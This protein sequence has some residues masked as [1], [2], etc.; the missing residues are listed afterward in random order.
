MVF[1]VPVVPITT[2][3]ERSRAYGRAGDRR[4]RCRTARIVA[5]AT[6][7]PLRLVSG[8]APGAAIRARALRTWWRHCR[9]SNAAA[10]AGR[11]AR[12]LPVSMA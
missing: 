6:T 5:P 10:D 4:R 7:S 8:T 12:P 11:Q 1:P 9:R 2:W 3:C